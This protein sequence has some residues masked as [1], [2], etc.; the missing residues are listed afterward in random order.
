VSA[1]PDLVGRT[2]LVTGANSGIG[3]ATVRGLAARGAAVLL[4]GRDATKLDAAAA[5]VAERATVAPRTFVAD[6]A[7][8]A[9]VARLA[10]DVKQAVPKLDLLVNNAGL[11]RDR[12]V[13]TDDG[14][15]LTLQ[16]NHLAPFLLTLRLLEALRAADGARVLTLASSAHANQRAL[17]LDDL[18]RP[19]SYRA[20]EAYARSKGCNILFT[21]ELA[22]RAAADGIAAYAVHP[23][24]VA[25]GFAREGDTTGW[26]RWLVTLF[27]PIM[28]APEKGADSVLWLAG[29]PAP[30]PS[31]A[32]VADRRER[33]PKAWARDPATAAALWSL[34]EALVAPH[35]PSE[36]P[37]ER[38]G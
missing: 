17:P 1:A 3:L 37:H 6:F 28:R 10:D 31:G 22:R 12:Y 19:P 25:T 9:D 23:G 14:V 2:A 34:S 35:L 16:V 27:R 21:R 36:G 26:L 33:E 18:V 7:R 30:P 29:T 8:L 4:H 20:F 24:V 15:E 11:I 32:Y 38:T 13:V 5:E